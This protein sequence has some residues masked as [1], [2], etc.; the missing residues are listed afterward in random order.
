MRNY[1]SCSK[2]ADWIRGTAKPGA[3][4]GQGW[5]DWRKKAK[6]SHPFRFWL[7]ETA[8]HS[9]Q[10]VFEYI[11]EK[12]NDVRYYI[13]NRWITK[14][15]ALT[16][17]PREIPRGEWRDVGG[18]F[19]PCLFNELVDFVEIEQ[20]WHHV[21]WD[22]EAREKYKT[23]WWRK[24]WLRLRTWRCPEAGIEHLEW[25]A[26]LVF[27]DQF[28][29]PTDLC[30]GKPTPQAEGAQEILALYKWWKESYLKRPDPMEASG[31]AAIYARERAEDEDDDDIFVSINRKR[32]KEQ[33]E[34]YNRAHDIQTAME[35]EY[36]R[37]EEEM[38]IRL[39]KIRNHLWT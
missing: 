29:K 30:Y 25:A 26:S 1:W 23:P 11:P 39:I 37:E 19:L 16:S 28:N 33:Q 20:A 2:F 36:E 7:T 35:A 10:N 18:R 14:T 17:H 6:S 22:S 9:I 21:M 27:D 31:V 12:L 3:A 32:T 15:H 4:T 34:E 38:M 5:S 13:N 24:G 8:L